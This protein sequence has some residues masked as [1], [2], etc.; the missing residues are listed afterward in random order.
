M[1][2]SHKLLFV[3]DRE[4][5]H[6]C[7]GDPDHHVTSTS[8]SST[9]SEV[10]HMTRTGTAVVAVVDVAHQTSSEFSV[11]EDMESKEDGEGDSEGGGGEVGGEDSELG[12]GDGEV[13]GGDSELG[14]GDSEL[15]GGGEDEKEVL[16][17]ARAR[18]KALL[19][20]KVSG[21][22]LTSPCPC[23][24]TDRLTAGCST[25]RLEEGALQENYS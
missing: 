16:K 20:R 21:V 22:C 1:D 3:E 13:G 4:P 9:R 19:R 5:F 23:W 2:Q 24:V 18:R 14:E 8:I 7:H 6:R 11:Q 25:I 15:G 10:C 17:S 12:G